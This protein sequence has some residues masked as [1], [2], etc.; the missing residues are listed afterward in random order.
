MK[1]FNPIIEALLSV[2]KGNQTNGNQVVKGNK[3]PS[4]SFANPDDAVCA[5]SLNSAWD[6]T[7]WRRLNCDPAGILITKG[8]AATGSDGA[9]G[10][11]ANS[12]VTQ[13]RIYVFNG[14][15]WDR[16]RGDITNGLDVDVTRQAT[17]FGKTIT[18]VQVTQAA[19]GT[20][21]LAAADAT[22]KH[23][24][25]GAVI[26]LDAGGTLLF[27]DGTLNSGAMPLAANTPLVLSTQ[28]LPYWETGAV[29]RALSLTSATGKAFGFVAV[30]TEA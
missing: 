1:K 10:A 18:Y 24:I 15:T 16:S 27:T 28:V 14:S 25:V 5:H 3:T 30:L 21:Q 8:N 6:A 12:N 26:S 11:T 23:K 13:G 2:I 19:A 9:S 7:Q 20:L 29:N 4:D 22:K 17:Y